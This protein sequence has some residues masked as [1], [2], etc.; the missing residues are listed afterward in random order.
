MAQLA[1]NRSFP[2]GTNNCQCITWN[3]AVDVF[4]CPQLPLV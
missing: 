4:M 3:P 2:T 1:E